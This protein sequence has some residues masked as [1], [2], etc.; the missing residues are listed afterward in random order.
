MVAI[1]RSDQEVSLLEAS[2]SLLVEEVGHERA[3]GI[4][5]IALSLARV[6]DDWVISGAS[7]DWGAGRLLPASCAIF[8]DIVEDSLRLRLWDAGARVDWTRH[9]SCRAFDE[10]AAVFRVDTLAFLRIVDPVWVLAFGWLAGLL[11]LIEDRVSR[12]VG[13]TNAAI[14][15]V[16]LLAK[17]T[18]DESLACVDTVADFLIVD[19]IHWIIGAFRV[20]RAAAV[21]ALIDIFFLL[22]NLQ[23][24][25]ANT[26]V[27][28]AVSFARVALLRDADVPVL[29]VAEIRVPVP[30]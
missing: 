2:A 24:W 14:V 4:E 18:C 23:D 26:R 19:P 13:N 29:A 22:L 28:N 6:M 5:D 27:I 25:D 9:S 12:L 17:R 16:D 7:L 30:A 8:F 10:Q 3:G 21:L 20:R 15:R 1:A 11:D